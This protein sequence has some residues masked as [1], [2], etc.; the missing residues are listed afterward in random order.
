MRNNVEINKRDGDMRHSHSVPE[1]DFYGLLSENKKKMKRK[2]E[3]FIYFRV[4]QFS[5]LEAYC[6]PKKLSVL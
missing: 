4:E 3:N 5:G 1:C 2:E 6:E